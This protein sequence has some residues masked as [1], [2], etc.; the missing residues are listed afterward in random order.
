MH[1]K[2]VLAGLLLVSLLEHNQI[3]SKF[4]PT[5]WRRNIPVFRAVCVCVPILPCMMGRVVP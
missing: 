1:S 5:K 3:E 2:L 4:I